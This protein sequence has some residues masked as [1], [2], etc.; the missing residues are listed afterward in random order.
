MDFY[1]AHIEMGVWKNTS[2]LYK[3]PI[4]KGA[5]QNPYGEEALQSP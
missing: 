4:E 1:K 3:A 5:L 2:G